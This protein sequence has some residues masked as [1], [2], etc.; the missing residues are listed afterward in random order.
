MKFTNHFLMMQILAVLSVS[1]ASQSLTAATTKTTTPSRAEIIRSVKSTKFL[2]E[3]VIDGPDL[4][5]ADINEGAPVEVINK[6]D[7]LQTAINALKKPS[8]KLVVRLTTGT[9]L[10][11]SNINAITIIRGMIYSL[12][13]DKDGYA[14][15]AFYVTQSTLDMTC[16][17][18]VLLPSLVKRIKLKAEKAGLSTKDYLIQEVK[19]N[20]ILLAISAS[21]AI[22]LIADLCQIVDAFAGEGIV[23]ESLYWIDSIIFLLVNTPGLTI[24][25]LQHGKKLLDH[26]YTN[27]WCMVACTRNPSKVETG[28]PL[29]EHS[30]SCP[31]T[32]DGSGMGGSYGAP[33]ET[34]ETTSSAMVPAEV[35]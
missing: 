8:L 20:K 35:A 34:K 25:L 10:I 29:A 14:S 11:L 9:S 4:Y 33:V 3:P 24:R 30:Q 6:I 12:A 1:I 2:P 13:Y 27:F 21:L 5:A 31:D 18:V 7:C 17:F 22:G 23:P 15:D 28:N 19:K 32:T 26:Q 16:T